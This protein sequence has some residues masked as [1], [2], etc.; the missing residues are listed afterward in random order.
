MSSIFSKIINREVSGHFIYE[1][2]VCVAI[3][4]KFP[5]LPGQ[6]LIIPKQEV[7]YVLDL[8]ETTYTHVCRVARKVAQALDVVFSAE[9]TC[10]VIEGFEV[11]HVHIKLYPMADGALPLGVLMKQGVVE[12]DAILADYALKLQKVLT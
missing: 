3:L 7:D 2:E 4:D 5:A 1:D 6:T 10:F 8:D 11:P 12:D 9:R